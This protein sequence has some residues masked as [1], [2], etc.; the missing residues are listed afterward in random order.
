MTDSQIK[1]FLSLGECGSF[2]VTADIYYV[3]Q[4]VVSKQ[5]IMLEQELGF[6]LLRRTAKGS[7]LTTAGEVMFKY[8]KQSQ[9]DLKKAVLEAKAAWYSENGVLSIG[10]ME[11]DYNDLIYECIDQLRKEHPNSDIK[12]ESTGYPLWETSIL[13]G[14][15]DIA[16][17][18]YVGESRDV[19][20]QPLFDEPQYILYHDNHPSAGKTDL[21]LKDFADTFFF[22]PITGNHALGAQNHFRQVFQ[23]HGLTSEPKMLLVHD[24]SQVKD[25]LVAGQGVAVCRAHSLNNPDAGLHPLKLSTNCQIGLS[26][27]ADN[28]NV[29]INKLEALILNKFSALNLNK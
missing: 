7:Y 26:K 18:F 10:L 1:Y 29:L 17:T 23:T 13:N 12:V 24:I 6:P 2:T 27:R 16:T 5:V 8:F 19:I 14:D 28:P 15:Y 4:S 21:S 22:L 20:F 9:A 3:S 25:L 11:T